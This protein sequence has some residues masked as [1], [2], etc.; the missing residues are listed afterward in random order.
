M[1]DDVDVTKQDLNTPLMILNPDID[2]KTALDVALGSDRTL[3][4]ELMLDMLEDF[5][6]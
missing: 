4:F 5:K 6:G 2:G 3:T 1:R